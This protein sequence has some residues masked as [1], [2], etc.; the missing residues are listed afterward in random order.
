MRIRSASNGI[1][2]M[3][4]AGTYVVLVG[5]DM[6]EA[7]ILDKQVLG[8]ALRRQRQSDGERIW[9]SGMKT[10]ES[11]E[12]HPIPGA[13]VSSFVHPLQTFQWCDYSAAPDQQYIYTVVAMTGTP[14]A[15]VSGP[16]V[17]LAVKTEPVDQGK[18]AIF[19]NRGAVGS[20]E[21]A[22]VFQN[23]PPDVVG[24]AAF[25]WL[26]RGL[27]E[28]LEAFIAQAGQGDQLLGAFFEFKSPRIYTALKAASARGATVRVLY[29]GDSEGVANEKALEGQGLTG[30]VKAREHSGGFAHNKFLVLRRGGESLQ[31]WT[32]STNLSTNGM[33]GH[34]NNAHIVRDGAIAQKYFD[35]W[36]LLDSDK[37][38]KPTATR[39]E[40]LSPLPPANPSLD[41][42]FSPRLNL[43]ALDWYA[44]LAAQASRGIFMTF[45]FGMNSR[46][47]PAFDVTD[48][49]IRF[50]LMEKKGTGTTYQE[51]AA[52][53]D[54]IRHH[55]NVTISVGNHIELNT[56]DRWLAELD[57]IDDN[58]HVLY[59]HTKYMLVDP[60]GDDPIV[61][62]GSANFSAASTTDNDENMLV[63]RGDT[64]VA[65]VYMGEFMRLFSHYAFRESLT[66]KGAL[67]P[68]S[69]LER[70]Y[71]IAST[72]WIRGPGRGQ[73]YF[74]PGTD[75]TLRRLYFSGQ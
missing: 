61:V 38:R 46:F 15:L 53:I 63:I 67:T 57:R 11:V 62:V 29:D 31:V 3:A 36:T 58:A 6:S 70:K 64:N 75:R 73:S 18:H 55:P 69:A 49:V 4:V 12:P 21:Y 50:A 59:V 34:S 10:F 23:M 1:T 56:F 28:G 7:E 24:P 48:N 25:D 72:E 19:F 54:R 30:M 45:A 20:Q 32:G 26:S 8:F 33:F 44:R 51:Q 22:R 74:R 35:Y 41:A 13:L 40:I 37:T 14:G 27:V 71:L 43:D 2:A 17:D 47:V 68:A 16:F 9:L 5:W 65:D 42:L 66:F 39:D 52:E 60:L